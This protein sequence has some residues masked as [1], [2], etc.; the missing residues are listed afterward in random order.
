MPYKGIVSRLRLTEPCH[1]PTA[2]SHND[3]A[4]IVNSDAGKES[5]IA[6][7]KSQPW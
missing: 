6:N 3:P 7:G 1:R 4:H 2:A 5:D